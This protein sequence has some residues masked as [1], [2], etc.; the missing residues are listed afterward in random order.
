M[1][2][3]WVGSRILTERS[4]LHHFPQRE[5]VQHLRCISE[6]SLMSANKF[7][8]VPFESSSTFFAPNHL[9]RRAFMCTAAASVG[10]L[11]LESI[12]L[13]AMGARSGGSVIRYPLHV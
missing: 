11:A 1:P 8:R 9:S 2:D 3:A 10:A 4:A 5:A 7:P 13:P 6:E 12:S